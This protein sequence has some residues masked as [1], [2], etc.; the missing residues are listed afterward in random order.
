MPTL[1]LSLC[2]IDQLQAY[3]DITGQAPIDKVA[4][5]GVYIT[6]ACFPNNVYDGEVFESCISNL[7]SA[8]YRRFIFD[9]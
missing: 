1:V 2:D 3:R 6:A 4:Y 8:Q 9:I 5:P 7:L